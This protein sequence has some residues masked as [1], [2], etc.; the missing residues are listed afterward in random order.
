MPALSGAGALVTKNSETYVELVNGAQLVGALAY[1]IGFPLTI[2][3]LLDCDINTY[4]KASYDVSFIRAISSYQDNL[5][6]MIYTGLG[7]SSTA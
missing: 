7:G 5:A 6:L 4:S 1:D 2:I 3:A